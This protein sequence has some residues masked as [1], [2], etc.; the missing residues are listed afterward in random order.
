MSS[1]IYFQRIGRARDPRSV[2]IGIERATV[3]SAILQMRS[4]LFSN[5]IYLSA[6]SAVTG[7]LGFAFWTVVARNYDADSVGVASA[8]ISAA[9]FLGFLASLGLEF[10]IIRFLPTR[11]T[12]SGD[13]LNAVLV[14]SAVS[15]FAMAFAFVAGVS[16]WSPALSVLRSEPHYGAVFIAMVIA[17]TLSGVLH[18]V[19]VAARKTIFVLLQSSLASIVRIPLAAIVVALIGTSGIVASWSAAL[20]IALMVSLFVYLPRVQSDIRLSLRFDFRGLGEVFRFSSFNYI[21]LVFWSAPAYVLPLI[22]VN[23]ASAEANAYFFGALAMAG[24]IWSIPQAISFSLLA[25]GSHQEG[26][27]RRQLKHSLWISVALVTPPIAFMVLFGDRLLGLFGAD[28]AREGFDTLRVLSLTAIPMTV[29]NLFLSVRRVQK[30]M[31]EIIGFSAAIPMVAIIFVYLRVSSEGIEV[32][33]LALLGTHTAGTIWVA[34]RA[35]SE[36]VKERASS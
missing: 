24:L 2:K 10:G 16:V 31:I 34:W 5:S 19:F 35:I 14:F 18:G 7:A 33:G 27:L 1:A 21:A 9:S 29:N 36:R 28:Y 13:L 12:R 6:T 25:E 3:K 8:I 22:V 32:A 15:S 23:R 30:K 17:I 11:G 4:S 20:A 26:L